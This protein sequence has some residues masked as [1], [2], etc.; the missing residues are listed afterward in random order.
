MTKRILPRGECP[1]CGNVRAIMLRGLCRR[2]YL[3]H[4][5][6]AAHGLPR[7]SQ[8]RRRFRTGIKI[9]TPRPQCGGNLI[10]RVG[11]RYGRLVVVERA[12]NTKGTTDAYWLC[13]C[14]CGKQVSVVAAALRSGNTKS[15]GC[16]R[17]RTGPRGPHPCRL[18]PGEA[19]R[20][21]LFVQYKRAAKSRNLSW[22]LAREEFFALIASPCFYCGEP[23]HRRKRSKHHDDLLYTGVDRVD[24]GLGYFPG[25]VVPCCHTYNHA[26]AT[27][28]QADFLAWIRRAYLHQ[29][30]DSC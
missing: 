29:T 4:D 2:C 22:E 9:L 10:D 8:P 3:D 21:M 12:E 5:T 7:Y 27:M 20:R 17:A 19:F 26:K 30:R 25:N 23:P 14:D 15:C 16:G 18:P 24:N 28:A 13:R 6:R 1:G 11:E